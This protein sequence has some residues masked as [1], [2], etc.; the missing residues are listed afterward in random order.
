MVDG[1]A[2]RRN[3]A[4]PID[5]EPRLTGDRSGRQP[6]RDE[7][8][9]QERL[10]LVHEPTDVLAPCGQVD[11]RVADEL[12]RTVVRGVTSSLDLDD[13]KPAPGRG[14]VV[15]LHADR[16]DRRMLY[17]DQRVAD[18]APSPLDDEGPH[19][20]ERVEVLAPA[21]VNDPRQGRSSGRRASA[22]RARAAPP[23]T[24]LR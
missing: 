15:P 8:I 14:A 1:D 4:T 19:G 3:L 20:A 5:P 13:G 12:P 11:D 9:R 17:E 7:R 22:R 21:P 6:Q 10:E 16:D 2:D 23:P 18:L 24:S